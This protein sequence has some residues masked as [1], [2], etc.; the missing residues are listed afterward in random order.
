[1]KMSTYAK[2][3]LGITVAWFVFALSA[4]ALHLFLNNSGI[5]IGVGVAASVPIVIFLLW[6]RFSA[7]FR[8]FTFS[9]N[10]RALTVVQFWR[11]IGFQFVLMEAR[12]LLPAMFALPAGYGDMFIGATAT[13]VAWKLANPDHRFSFIVWQSL[14]IL[15]LLVAVSLGTTARLIDPHGIS[16][17]PMTVL[18]LSLIPTFFVPLFL[19]LHIIC[20]AQA[21][22]W[23][24]SS[25]QRQLP[26]AL[27][28]NYPAKQPA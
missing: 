10:P 9:L 25:T 23:R 19:I 24:A 12:S 26:S 28:G 8:E 20:I 14:G 16:M 22:G 1:M 3:T 7:S 11:L 5:G 21:R 18:P 27:P 2:L 15:D 17:V 6:F 4:S 13:L